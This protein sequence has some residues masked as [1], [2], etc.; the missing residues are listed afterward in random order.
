MHD[1]LSSKPVSHPAPT[2]YSSSQPDSPTR[3][4]KYTATRRKPTEPPKF[5]PKTAHSKTK[6]VKFDMK[7]GDSGKINAGN[8]LLQ[9]SLLEAPLA[10]L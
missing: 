4:S 8:D 5:T 2:L 9:R 1:I 7:H 10:S 6:G 3:R